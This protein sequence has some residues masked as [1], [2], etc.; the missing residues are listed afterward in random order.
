M[1]SV[2]SAR[3]WAPCRSISATWAAETSPSFASA[4][5]ATC[6][7]HALGDGLRDLRARRAD[8]ALGEFQRAT[9]RLADRRLA[10]LPLVGE[11]G[12]D[13]LAVGLKLGP[14][15]V[16]KRSLE[17]GR[18]GGQPGVEV[19]RELLD[20]G[21]D[22]FRQRPGRRGDAGPQLGVEALATLRSGGVDPLV[23]LAAHRLDLV[24][25]RRPQ[26]G[27]QLLGDLADVL[28]GLPGDALDA[29]LEPLLDALAELGAHL[30]DPLG[31]LVAKLVAD[32]RDRRL[33][34]SPEVLALVLDP[35]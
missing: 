24:G 4:A 10:A 25:D 7:T 22:A 32:R 9:E 14:E 23:E 12:A 31:D 28:V 21:A 29:L 1:C 27:A 17:L 30:L 35:L 33:A 18:A 6:S 19:A 16:R 20:R 2:I 34:A 3:A 5:A 15:A 8:L 26:L 13:R 11:L